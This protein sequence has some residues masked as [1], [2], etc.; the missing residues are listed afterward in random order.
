V[1]R[2]HLDA[3]R[4]VS[5]ASTR[6]PLPSSAATGRPSSASRARVIGIRV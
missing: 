3:N 4:T 6:L 2:A 5:A 1:H